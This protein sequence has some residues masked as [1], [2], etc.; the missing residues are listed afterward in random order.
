MSD[1]E[2]RVGLDELESY[3]AFGDE[4]VY[5][6][7]AIARSKEHEDVT[8]TTEPAIREVVEDAQDLGRKIEHLD[9]VVSRFDSRYRLYLSANARDTTTAFFELRERMDDWL[10]MR[11][12]G[13]EEV[14]PKFKRVDSEFKSVLQSDTCKAE[15]NFIFDLDD[16]T[17]AEA[18]TFRNRLGEYTTVRMVRETPNG[19]HVVTESFNY[20]EFTAAIEYELK[21]DGLVFLTY[22]TG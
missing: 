4:R 17:A 16:V 20:T 22:A 7:L 12:G 15:P 14:L 8:G 3:C 9:Q 21:T 11:L 6:L 10:R 1:L 5:L 18:E 13:N 19:Y 2:A